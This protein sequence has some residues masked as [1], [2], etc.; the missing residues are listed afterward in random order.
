VQALLEKSIAGQWSLDN[1]IDWD[2]P[3][4]VPVWIKRQTYAKLISQFYHGERLTQKLCHAL[5]DRVARPEDLAFVRM[6]L[7]DEIRHAEVYQKYIETFHDILP[8]SEEL[9]HALERSLEWSGSPLG[10]IASVHVVFE[11]GTLSLL[12]NLSKSFPCP[13]FRQMNSLIMPDEA[14]HFA[15]GMQHIKSEVPGLSADERLELY[16]FVSSIWVECAERARKR[17]R[18]P[19]LLATRLSSNWLRESWERQRQL[20]IKFGL[21][22]QFESDN[23]DRENLSRALV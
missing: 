7:A 14:R 6:Q 15:F 12:E 5:I 13:L 4:K 11:G 19:A 9:E 16:R 18:L 23:L 22:T 2:L 17:Q 1:D 21:V 20:L 8:V 3:I 10:L